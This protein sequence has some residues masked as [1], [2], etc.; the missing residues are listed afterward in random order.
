MHYVMRKVTDDPLCGNSVFIL[1][2]VWELAERVQAY[3][4]H[5][6]RKYATRRA[7]GHIAKGTQVRLENF[8]DGSGIK[9]V[10]E[11]W[12]IEG[13]PAPTHVD[14]HVFKNPAHCVTLIREYGEYESTEKQVAERMG[15][16]GKPIVRTPYEGLSV[17]VV[18]DEIDD[19]ADRFVLAA[20]KAAIKHMNRPVT[21]KKPKKPSPTDRG[22]YKGYKQWQR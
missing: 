16:I 13:G 22:N 14:M 9:V 17:D 19:L 21:Y 3:S 8:K 1:E 15:A 4:P 11:Y 5:A 10:F 7:A 20:D 2:N 6:I 12:Q 18:A